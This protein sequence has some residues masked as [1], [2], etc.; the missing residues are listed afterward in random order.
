MTWVARGSECCGR[1]L[2]KGNYLLVSYFESIC[3]VRFV[4]CCTRCTGAVVG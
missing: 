1:S 4:A 3:T 2:A